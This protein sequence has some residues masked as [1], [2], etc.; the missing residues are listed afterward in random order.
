[1]ADEYMDLITSC[2]ISWGA[3]AVVKDGESAASTRS[4]HRS[5]P[6]HFEGQFFK[7]RGP[8]NTGAAVAAGGRPT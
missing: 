2:S 5:I 6:D 8:L 7:C 3:G 1:L 4:P